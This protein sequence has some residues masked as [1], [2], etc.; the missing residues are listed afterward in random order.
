MEVAF[1]NYDGCLKCVNGYDNKCK[2][3]NKAYHQTQYNIYHYMS[4]ITEIM[5][6]A[7]VLRIFINLFWNL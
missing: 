7:A 5:Y 6:Y 2:K 1:G 4:Y 3:C